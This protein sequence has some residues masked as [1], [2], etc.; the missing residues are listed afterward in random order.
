MPW[1]S[2]GVPPFTYF[3][4]KSN[5]LH[6]CE[7][8]FTKIQLTKT[9]RTRSSHGQCSPLGHFLSPHNG[10]KDSSILQLTPQNDHHCGTPTRAVREIPCDWDLPKPHGRL[11]SVCRGHRSTKPTKEI[12]SARAPIAPNPKRS[13]PLDLDFVALIHRVRGRGD[14]VLQVGP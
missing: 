4:E 12:K 1:D 14:M 7:S 2:S 13:P 9:V 8:T 10:R 11:H 3:I 5:V 6:F